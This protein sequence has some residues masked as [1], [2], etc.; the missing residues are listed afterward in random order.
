MDRRH[1]PGWSSPSVCVILSAPW[2]SSVCLHLNYFLPPPLNISKPT[3]SLDT[4]TGSLCLRRDLVF[5]PDGSVTVAHFAP[6][7]RGVS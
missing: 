5:P 3:L 7:A 2:V 6:L 1:M 4:V